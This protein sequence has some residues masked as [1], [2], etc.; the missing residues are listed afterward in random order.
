MKKILLTNDDGIQSEGLQTLVE[1][2]E[3]TG[4]YEVWVAAPD[5]ERSAVSHCVT[6]RAPVRF[7]RTAER[8][9]ACAGTPADC[10]LY[11]LKGAVPFKPD[12][13]IS[14][15]NHGANVGTD[16]VYSGTVAAARQAAFHGLPAIALSAQG[17]NGQFA[18]KAAAQLLIENLP[19]ILPL[20]DRHIVININVPEAY[21]CPGD[22]Y[23][24][25]PAFRDYKDFIEPFQRSH[26]EVYYFI[27]GAGAESARVFDE[28]T[29]VEALDEGAASISPIEVNPVV[30]TE[31]MLDF[32]RYFKTK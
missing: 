26:D 18:F 30:R 29:D 20:W 15:I 13:V 9:Y 25:H 27:S 14:G 24:T 8:R 6:L 2:L 19:L 12:L 7:M 16:I 22:I 4:E 11:S 23:L 32:S 21:S 17:R 5:K 31:K 28:H 3:K 1:A 10:V